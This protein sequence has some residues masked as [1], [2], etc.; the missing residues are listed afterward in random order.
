MTEAA[1]PGT[2]SIEHVVSRLETIQAVLPMVNGVP[3]FNGLYLEVTQAVRE[4]CAHENY[5]QHA[6][7]I[8]RLDVV[9]AGYYFD[10]VDA[11]H[12]GEPVPKAWGP[13]F[14]PRE[15]AADLHPLQFALAGMNAHINHDLVF[16]IIQTCQEFGIEPEEGS[17]QHVDFTR[18]NVLLGEVEDVIKSRYALGL[19]GDVD[20]RFGRVDDIFVMWNV[21]RAREMAWDWAEMLWPLREDP[22]LFAKADKLIGRLV[23]FAGRGLTSLRLGE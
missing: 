15:D 9:F 11:S 8:E 3:A 12:R 13:L 17:A 21:G 1:V 5:F 2:H 4:R 18:V 10:A 23:G 16:A 19:V 20:K 22:K 6:E 14:K 7:W